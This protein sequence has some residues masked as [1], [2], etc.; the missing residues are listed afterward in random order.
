M[1]F[2][3]IFF[4]LQEWDISKLSVI[5][6]L[7]SI[8]FIFGLKF[9]IQKYY[10]PYGKPEFFTAILLVL[11]IF[12]S[13]FSGITSDILGQKISFKFYSFYLLY[14]IP[15]FSVFYGISRKLNTDDKLQFRYWF[16]SFV[17][18]FIIC[19][20]LFHIYIWIHSGNAEFLMER[21]LFNMLYLPIIWT[22]SGIGF[23]YLGLKKNIPEFNRIGFALIG[24]MIIKLY[25][26]D[27][28]QMDHV[29]RIVAFIVLG[30]LLL[31]GSFVFQKLKKV[32]GL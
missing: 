29:S 27:V 7:Y 20:E 11:F 28:W 16:I 31:S 5:V 24:I 26:V 12:I 10:K 14:L 8:Y 3:E 13:G 2:L 21:K 18:I 30:I 17:F 1:I 6:L 15:F 32:L 25:A 19:K 23:I 9:F 4:H 22:I